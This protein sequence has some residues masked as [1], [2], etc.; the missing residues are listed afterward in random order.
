MI[1]DKL[2]EQVGWLKVTYGLALAA[3]ISQIAWIFNNFE[4]T[5][6]LKL[7]IAMV[8]T[9]IITVVVVLTNKKANEKMNQLEEL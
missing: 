8:S 3:D 7:T 1:I 9:F 2:K 4:N 5:S 6:L